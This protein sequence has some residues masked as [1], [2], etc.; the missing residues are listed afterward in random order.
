M[1]DINSSGGVVDYLN[2]YNGSNNSCSQTNNGY[3][4]K[5]FEFPNKA[6]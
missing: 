2:R 3:L 5:G 4:G 1:D 6:I